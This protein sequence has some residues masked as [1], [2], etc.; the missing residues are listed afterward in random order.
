MVNGVATSLAAVV[1]FARRLGTVVFRSIRALRGDPDHTVFE[2]LHKFT[3]QTLVS[4]VVIALVM[5][6][7]AAVTWPARHFSGRENGID[8]RGSSTPTAAVAALP[9]VDKLQATAPHWLVSAPWARL[10]A[11][12]LST[13][14]PG[15]TLLRAH[16]DARSF[17]VAFGGVDEAD[18]DADDDIGGMGLPSVGRPEQHFDDDNTALLAAPTPSTQQMQQQRRSSRRGNIAR[19]KFRPLQ[20]G[21]RKGGFNRAHPRRISSFSSTATDDSTTISSMRSTR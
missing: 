18:D 15:L 9:F 20:R 1:P 21:S 5:P 2:H 4:V 19:G 3:P 14:A 10:A 17:S 7:V 12:G 8:S 16:A 11:L 6:Y 13:A